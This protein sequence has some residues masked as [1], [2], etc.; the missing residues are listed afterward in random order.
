MGHNQL[1]EGDGGPVT[2][3]LI[4]DFGVLSHFVPKVSVNSLDGG[5]SLLLH[6][7]DLTQSATRKLLG[8]A[9]L[10]YFLIGVAVA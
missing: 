6:A 4:M 10:E 5:I 3:E 1:G 7:L 2:S 8:C 9:T